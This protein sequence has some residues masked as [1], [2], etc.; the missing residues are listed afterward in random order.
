MVLFDNHTQTT[1]LLEVGDNVYDFTIENSI[2]S[3]TA[4]NRFS[5][6]FRSITFSV[7]EFE[8]NPISIFP[9]PVNSGGTINIEI[10]GNVYSS[11]L[12]LS[13]FSLTGKRM[14]QKN[15]T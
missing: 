12:S 7:N 13:V 2:P 3:I 9:N 14:Y 8:K 4:S 11:D 1:T 5:L 10:P 15:N 6:R